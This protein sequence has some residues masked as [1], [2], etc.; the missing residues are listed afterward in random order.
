MKTRDIAILILLFLAA[1]FCFWSAAQRSKSRED[2]KFRILSEEE[3][4]EATETA[5]LEGV[6]S[7]NIDLQKIH[8]TLSIMLLG[9]VRNYERRFGVPSGTNF[10]AKKFTSA[11]VVAN[12]IEA[13]LVPI[14][15]ILTNNAFVSKF[16]S[17][18]TMKLDF[19][20]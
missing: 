14:S 16:G 7:T 15:S 3:M 11:Q 4:Y 20:K 8:S 19:E 1:G 10:W 5:Y 6:R 17:N 2:A 9:D 12:Q 13:T 18:A